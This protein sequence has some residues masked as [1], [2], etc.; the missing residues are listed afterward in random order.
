MTD[1]S[2]KRNSV[3]KKKS[4][5]RVTVTAVK[6]AIRENI[7]YCSALGKHFKVSKQYMHKFLKKM[8]E[9]DEIR[10]DVS[11][12]NGKVAIYYKVVEPRV[13]QTNLGDW[14]SQLRSQ[15]YFRDGTQIS[16]G[17][18]NYDKWFQPDIDWKLGKTLMKG[19]HI[20]NTFIRIA[21]DKTLTIIFPKIFGKDEVEPITKAD[22]KAYQI[23][24]KFLKMYP[25]FELTPMPINMKLGNLGT[26]LLNDALKEYSGI[27]TDNF[28]IDKTPNKGSLEMNITDPIQASENMRDTVDFFATG[29][30]RMMMKE[31][32]LMRK[33]MNSNA[34]TLNSITQTQLMIAQTL[35]K[36]EERK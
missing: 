6:K 29:G 2:T 33:I 31:L 7:T 3:K 4:T 1:Y 35:K 8:L 13:I 22:Y 9:R 19:I 15:P 12:G 18:L 16:Y 10:I 27:R 14:V 26:T 21:N 36:M 32:I 24:S 34:G 25:D 5:K 28:I 30:L 17:I 23:K 11:E 20:D